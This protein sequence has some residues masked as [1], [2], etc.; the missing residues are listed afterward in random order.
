MMYYIFT[1]KFLTPVHFGDTANGGSLDKFSVQCSADTLFAALG[2]EAANKGSD[3]VET[4]VKKTVEGKIV[5]S[6]LFP[7]CRTVDDDLYFYL[8]KPLLK[9]EQDEQQSA[10]SFEEIKQLATKLKKQKKSTYIRASQINSL[11]ESGSSDRQFAVPEFAAPL[12]AGRVALRE[13]KPLPYY[14]GSYVFSEHS[15]LYFILGVEHEEEFTLIKEL[16]LSLGYSGIGGKRSSGYGKFELA[17]DEL[18]LFDDG[19]VYDDDTAIALMLYNEKSKYQMCL[20]PVC[21]KADELAVVKQGRN[22]LIKRGGFITSSAVKDNIKRNSIYMLQ[23]GSC[24]PERLC[25]QM[26]QQT[27]DG[28][29]HDVYRDGIGMFVGLKNE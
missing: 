7:Y 27:V 6:S 15:G 28:L 17:D 16:L 5:F 3:A 23:E 2:N 10:K 24:F 18:E 26:L 1:L 22:K 25:G 11:L 19:G 8:P 29:A 21:P 20:A 12:V 9:L 4:L 14:V 13:E